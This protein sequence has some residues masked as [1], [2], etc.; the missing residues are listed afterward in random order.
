MY[1]T[2]PPIDTSPTYLHFAVQASSKGQ[3]CQ[4]GLPHLISEPVDDTI[5]WLGVRPQRIEGQGETSGISLRDGEAVKLLHPLR[6]PHRQHMDDKLQAEGC[7]MAFCETKL[8]KIVP[9]K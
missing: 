8:G 3:S 2:Q 4:A 6:A 7:A 1:S 5:I 9:K